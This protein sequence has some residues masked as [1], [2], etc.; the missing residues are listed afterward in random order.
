MKKS[1][2]VLICVA[3]AAAMFVFL[4]FG[5]AQQMQKV[6]PPKIAK[7]LDIA[8]PQLFIQIKGVRCDHSGQPN[9]EIDL[10]GQNFGAQQGSRRVLVDGVPATFYHAWFNTG[11]TTYSPSGSPTKWYHEY[12]FAIDDGTGKIISNQFKIRFP[13]D[14][15]G[16]TPG[17]GTPGTEV[18]LYCWGPGPNQ[19]N[20]ILH[21]D[22]AVMQVTSWT[23][24]GSAIQI[25]AIVPQVAAGP[26]KIF[27]MDG[28]DKISKELSFTVL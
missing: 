10:S 21:L 3:A 20:K 14:W 17:Q 12:T 9:P 27:F 26:H 19:G 16:V 2:V 5:A 23:G 7:P 24:T 1:G 18:L 22:N 11:I 15:D 8:K 28:T 4:S 6:A 25:K 13:I